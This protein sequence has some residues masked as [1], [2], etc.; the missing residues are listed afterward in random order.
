MNNG[1]PLTTLERFPDYL[2]YL[3]DLGC[4][5][6]DKISSGVIAKA[7]GL[8]EVLVRKD[9]ACTGCAGKPRVGYVVRDLIAALEGALRC[10][11]RKNAVIVGVGGLGSALL[12]YGG[13]SKYG[14][15]IVAGF[16]I[17][18]AKQTEENGKPVLPMEYLSDGVKKYG[19]ALAVICVPASAAQGVCDALVDSGI[20]G[21]LTFAPATLRA[22]SRISVR[23][24]DVAANLA[25]LAS[26]II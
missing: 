10:D 18:P 9:L 2:N 26:G 16:D 24:M 7:L 25:I 14:I 12:A 23:H 6:D 11:T 3:R 8:G 1:I 13:F 19:A 5:D 21:I 22:D 4:G 20:T 15:D 17:D